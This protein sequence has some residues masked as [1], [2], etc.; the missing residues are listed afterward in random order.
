[1]Y[2]PN[3]GIPTMCEIGWY[4]WA[5]VFLNGVVVGVGVTWLYVLFNPFWWLKK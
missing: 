5:A 2:A 3:V 4:W 1:M